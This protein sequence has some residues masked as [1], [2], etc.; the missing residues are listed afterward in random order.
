MVYQVDQVYRF[1]SNLYYSLGIVQL[2]REHCKEKCHFYYNTSPR[3]RTLYT[4][5]IG[6][7]ISVD[8]FD[9]RPTF[10]RD[11]NQRVFEEASRFVAYAENR[12]ERTAEAR[13]YRMNN[14]FDARRKSIVPEGSLYQWL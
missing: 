9:N 2:C 10:R 5:S 14:K 8:A 13:H 12:N 6:R 1:Y 7:G 4:G 3:T 11:L